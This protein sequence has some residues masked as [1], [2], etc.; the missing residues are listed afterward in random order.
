MKNIILCVYNTTPPPLFYHE[1]LI[2]ISRIM[3]DEIRYVYFHFLK[4]SIEYMTFDTV[5]QEPLIDLLKAI[6]VES[7]DVQLLSNLYWKQ[8]AAVRLVNG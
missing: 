7:H 5:R 3:H 4:A 2:K 1:D 6:D 8:K